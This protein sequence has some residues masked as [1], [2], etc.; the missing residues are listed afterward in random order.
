[1]LANYNDAVREYAR[2]VG[3]EKPEQCWLLSS[4]DTWVRNPFYKGEPVRHPEEDDYLG[5]DADSDR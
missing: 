1:M 4:Y 5:D 3:Q 2:N